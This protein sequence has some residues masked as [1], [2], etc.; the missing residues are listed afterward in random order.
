MRYLPVELD[1]DDVVGRIA[2]DLIQSKNTFC[3]CFAIRLDAA[4]PKADERDA[5][6]CRTRQDG[7]DE[8]S[9]CRK[10]KAEL[11]V[12]ESVYGEGT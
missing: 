10:V 12:A 8:R 7:Q 2:R 11:V 4:R 1:G 6:R 5:H 3:D 9:G